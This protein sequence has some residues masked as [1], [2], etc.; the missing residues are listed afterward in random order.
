M[1]IGFNPWNL[2][3]SLKSADEW[4]ETINSNIIGSTRNAY[5]SSE[6]MFGGGLTRTLKP[7]VNNKAGIM[8]AETQVDIGYTKINWKQGNIQNTESPTDFA[9]NG[10][11]FFIVAD[12]KSTN[13]AT[14]P[15]YFNG[16][17]TGGAQKAYLTRDGNF[18]FAIVTNSAGVNVA[19]ASGISADPSAAVLV[20]NEGLVVMGD[21]L[22]TSDNWHAPIT[23]TDFDA[24]T[25]ARAFTRP[26]IVEPTKDST[27]G[28]AP[29]VLVEYQDL[30]F[31]K[32]GST[33]YEAPSS[34]FYST[35]VN[36][37]NKVLDKR[38]P[39]DAMD[40]QSRLIEQALEG[41]NVDVEKEIVGL[42]ASKSFYE[43]LTKN[44]TV[45]LDNID[46]S[47]RLFR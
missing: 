33:I 28:G 21:F 30:Q 15:L 9:I 14:S 22:G 13:W 4:G 43:A 40:R 41:S 27:S 18:H 17:G 35:I 36:G 31:S 38:D 20:N 2:I 26:S 34:T 12:A 16:T 25:G 8:V 42:N 23:K 32:Y 5:K 6:V 47:L 3:R 7:F 19:V 10:R 24:T 11:G 44:F 45:Y 29:N 37:S 39:A 46:S 1:S